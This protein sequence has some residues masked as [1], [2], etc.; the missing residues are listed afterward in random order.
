[1]HEGFGNAMYRPWVDIPTVMVS[2]GHPYLLYDAPKVPAYINAYSP[3][4]EVQ[5]A[6]VDGLLGRLSFNT[7]AT[8][9]PFCGLEQLRY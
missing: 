5:K 7:D 2:F 6:V 9:D 1:L 8:I 3:L 4:V